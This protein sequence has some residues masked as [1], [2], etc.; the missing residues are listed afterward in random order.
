VSVRTAAL[1]GLVVGALV[2][3]VAW[4]FELPLG[5]VAALAPIVVVASAAAVGL[6]VFWIRVAL[7][8]LRDAK[9]PRLIV[10]VGV[11]VLL[12]VVLLTLLGIQL[13]RE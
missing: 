7:N 5:R 4:A 10:G 1:S 13:P 11:G 3:L 9:H 2:L 8:E 12:A 6:F